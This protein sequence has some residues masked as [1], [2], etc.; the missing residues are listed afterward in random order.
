VIA[1]DVGLTGRL[2]RTVIIDILLRRRLM[3]VYLMRE[4]TRKSK[5]AMNVDGGRQ[6]AAEGSAENRHEER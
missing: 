5:S 1:A 4:C 6:M 3:G 2:D